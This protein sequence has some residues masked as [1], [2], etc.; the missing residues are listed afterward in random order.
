VVEE[1]ASVKARLQELAMEKL[2]QVRLLEQALGS[3]LQ[4]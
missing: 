1:R 4:H 2:E 3:L